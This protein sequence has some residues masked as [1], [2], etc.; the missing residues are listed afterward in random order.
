M[1]TYSIAPKHITAL[2][3]LAIGFPV[4]REWKLIVKLTISELAILRLAIGF[5]VWREWKQSATRTTRTHVYPCDRLS[6][7]KGMETGPTNSKR[8][9]RTL[10][11]DRLSR[12]KG[13]ETKTLAQDPLKCTLLAI[14]FP[15]WREWKPSSGT[16][17]LFTPQPRTCDR[18]SRLKG[19]ETLDIEGRLTSAGSL[20]IGFPVW[21]EWKRHNRILFEWIVSILR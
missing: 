18:L 9:S 1:E 15:V 10:T 2:T 20:A 19:M 12:L 11:C 8:W 6:R 16:T 5:P 13:I 21:R 14:G 17:S 7:L 3:K 4:W